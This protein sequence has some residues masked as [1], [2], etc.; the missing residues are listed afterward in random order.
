MSKPST[1]TATSEWAKHL[2][3]EGKRRF[4]SSER[5]NSKVDIQH[6]LNQLEEDEDNTSHSH[7][8][9]SFNAQPHKG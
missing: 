9:S 3:R 8:S 7:P 5:L 1:L 6:Q 4:H 2:R